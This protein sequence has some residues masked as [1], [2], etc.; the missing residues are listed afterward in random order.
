MKYNE[1]GFAELLLIPLVPHIL[2]TC[3]PFLHPPPASAFGYL[4]LLLLSRAHSLEPRCVF[5]SDTFRVLREPAKEP[6]ITRSVGWTSRVLKLQVALCNKR[7][8]ARPRP[9][10]GDTGSVRFTIQVSFKVLNA[11]PP[12]V[13]EAVTAEPWKSASAQRSPHKASHLHVTSTRPP[14]AFVS[15]WW[16]ANHGLLETWSDMNKVTTATLPRG[17]KRNRIWECWECLR[18]PTDWKTGAGFHSST[19]GDKSNKKK[20]ERVVHLL[21]ALKAFRDHE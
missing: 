13:F 12:V 4:Q 7:Y 14:A 8:D 9:H 19:T 10:N 20:S 16:W 5:S 3:P 2:P 21:S 11:G 18:L 17:F 6:G 15:A 1:C